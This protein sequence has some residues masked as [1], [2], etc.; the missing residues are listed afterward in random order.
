MTYST[1]KTNPETNRAWQQRSRKPLAR[2]EKELKRTPMKQVSKKHSAEKREY[3]PV[4]REFLARHPLCHHCLE[5]GVA[6]LPA[7]EIHHVAGKGGRMRNDTRF[8]MAVNSRCHTIDSKSIHQN[9][10]DAYERGWMISRGATMAL[11]LLDLNIKRG[12]FEHVQR[13]LKLWEEGQ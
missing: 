9:T 12:H 10:A 2:S 13:E 8:F 6:A 3:S 7:T 4:A 11:K 1:L 5:K